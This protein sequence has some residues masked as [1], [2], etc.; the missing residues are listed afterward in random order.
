MNFCG[1]IKG[2]V[3][4]KPFVCPFL[5]SGM[6]MLWSF[7][8]SLTL[9]VNADNSNQNWLAFEGEE[10]KTGWILWKSQQAKHHAQNC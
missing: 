6:F 5:V 2:E 9:P 7:S 10:L 1:S 3:V 4:L 8:P